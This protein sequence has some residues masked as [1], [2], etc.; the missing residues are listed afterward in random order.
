MPKRGG[1]R[2]PGAPPPFD[3]PLIYVTMH[4]SCSVVTLLL[5]LQCQNCSTLVQLPAVRTL[6]CAQQLQ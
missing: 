4:F 1:G 5:P 2:N 3:V 6:G